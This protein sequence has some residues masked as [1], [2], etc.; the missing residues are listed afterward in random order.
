[1]INKIFLICMASLMFCAQKLGIS[2]QAINVWIFCVIWPLIT[3]MLI[4]FSVNCF[5]NH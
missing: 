3:L 4:I 2:Y 5:L 1:M